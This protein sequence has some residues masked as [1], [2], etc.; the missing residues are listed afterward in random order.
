[1]QRKMCGITMFGPE[2]AIVVARVEEV[3]RKRN[4]KERWVDMMGGG[5]A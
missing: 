5:E 1:M 3:E 2:G 4:I